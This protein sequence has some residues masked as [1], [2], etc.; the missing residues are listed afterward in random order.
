MF[1]L[2]LQLIDPKRFVRAIDTKLSSMEADEKSLEESL[3]TS[4]ATSND[5]EV[6]KIFLDLER[7]ERKASRAPKVDMTITAPEDGNDLKDKESEKKEDK[8]DGTKQHHKRSEKET[9]KEILFRQ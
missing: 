5:N 7:E 4:R 6:D 2:P 8:E 3:R 1:F 9:L